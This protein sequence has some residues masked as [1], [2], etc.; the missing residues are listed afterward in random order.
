M[1][2]TSGGGDSR[3]TVAGQVD[4]LIAA[5][6]T[7]HLA[8]DAHPLGT[9]VAA[10]YPTTP[11][12]PVHTS[13]LASGGFGL[14]SMPTQ[15]RVVC[16]FTTAKAGRK[17]RGRTYGFTPEQTKQATDGSVDTTL[18]NGWLQVF[19]QFRVGLTA[20]GSVW[21]LV[22]NHKWKGPPLV[23]VPPDPVVK[24]AIQ[25]KWGTQRRGGWYGRPNSAPWG[26]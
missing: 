15:V 6:I 25:E 11:W 19:E 3:M 18:R 24:V 14:H 7:P 5:W 17:Y 9:R 10:T 8:P 1:I 23:Y 16:S 22:I 26:P 20:L 13:V 12:Q 4:S 2:T 21:Q